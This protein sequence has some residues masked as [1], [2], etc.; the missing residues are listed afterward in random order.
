M[1]E[2]PLLADRLR[3]AGHLEPPTPTARK[4][5]L[6]EGPEGA[7]SNGGV[8]QGLIGRWLVC[9]ER[10]RLYVVEGLRPADQFNHKLEFGSMWHACEESLAAAAPT[11]S[12]NWEHALADYADKLARHYPTQ[13][14]QIEHWWNVV[15][16]QFP[17][18][19]DYWKRHPDT[20][21][22]R[23][24]LQEQVFDVPY[25][26]PSGRT[27]R[28]RGRWD[29]VDLVGGGDRAG[30]WLGENK[31]KGDIREGQIKRQLL[32]DLQT[33]F[34]TIALQRLQEVTK[35]GKLL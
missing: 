22:R 33:L 34:Y 28:L 6:W 17:L 32:F 27:V 15:R 29:S 20:L 10:F 5:P 8:T 19:I 12:P 13:R 4:G 9:R 26:L 18:Y 31:T 11:R 25:L 21:A 1:S 7:G 3:R 2:T 30:V 16:I 35:N 24:L 23:P 14:Q